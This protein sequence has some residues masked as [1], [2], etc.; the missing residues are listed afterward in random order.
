MHLARLQGRALTAGI[1]LT[2]GVGFMLFGWD[3]GVYGGILGN[4]RFLATFDNPS[5]TI[6]GQIVST[7][8]IGCIL[9][10]FLSFFVGDRYGRRKAIALACLSVA[11]G[12]ALQASAFSLTH[13]IVGRI[14]AGLGIGL[15]SATIPMWQ[16]ETSKPEHRGK[17]IALQLVLVIFG[18]DLTQWV[19]LGMTY[20]PNNDVSWRFPIAFQCFLALLTMFLLWFMPESPRWLCY[21]GRH[22]EAQEIM[23]R[24]ESTT[25]DDPKVQAEIRIILG[26]ISH[27]QEVQPVTWREVFAGGE[28]QDLRRI[29]LG[30]G[31]SL[32]QQF[33]GINVVVY[34]LPVI[35]TQSFGFSSRMALIL[36]AVDF[37]S[38]CFWGLMIFFVID[39][40]GRKNLMLYGALGQSFCF[41]MAAIG[42]G[43][44]T[45]AMNG[46][47]VAFI[48]FYHICFGLS[49]LSIPFMYPSEINSQRMR[50]T[51]NA[52]AMI[53][54][55]VGVYV[56][57]SITPPAIA[58]IGWRFYIIFAVL[59]FAWVPFI[60]YFYVETAGLS[61]EEVD[62][63]FAI[64]H[65]G[66]KDMTYKKARRLALEQRQTVLLSMEEKEMQVTHEDFKA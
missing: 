18:I 13:M 62:I 56:I 44:G 32:M 19:N 36:S 53:T 25:S 52:V 11:I 12:G 40:V 60:W 43:I 30:A 37:I 21:K 64:K 15:N 28:Q 26:T 9:G 23:A 27:E 33:G 48:F 41:A 51:G 66:G 50:N 14:I 61:L 55:W 2:S 24:L 57:V 8:D 22:E 3:Q 58:N 39:R 59:N 65:N 42:L 45:T 46:I 49:F 29:L 5:A 7:Y 63:M 20:V 35:L 6:Q 47:A 4:E 31:T 38:L 16:S 10:A 34:Y 54:N 1:T 17:L